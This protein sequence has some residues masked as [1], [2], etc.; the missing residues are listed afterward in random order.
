MS[1]SR[2][3]GRGASGRRRRAPGLSTAL[4]ALLLLAAG[5]RGGGGGGGCDAFSAIRFLADQAPSAGAVTLAETGFVSSCAGGS[6]F[7]G[8]VLTST[9]NVFGTDFDLV[10]DSVDFNFSGAVAGTFL[11]EGGTV[12]TQLQVTRKPDTASTERLVVAYFR[13][14]VATPNVNAVGEQTLLVL[15]FRPKA[16]NMMIISPLGFDASVKAM[17]VVSKDGT[18]VVGAAS[19][20]GGSLR[21]E[22]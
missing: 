18:V 4:G 13:E 21:I 19:F 7:V 20:F 15:E 9:D 12:S 11:S 2:R 5:C 16:A 10:Y 8:V 22:V 17:R 3:G 14:G 6:V 1:V